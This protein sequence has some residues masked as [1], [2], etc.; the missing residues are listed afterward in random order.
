MGGQWCPH[1]LCCSVAAQSGEPRGPSEVGRLASK[2][3][4]QA[5]PHLGCFVDIISK[6]IEFIH[7]IP[8]TGVA[9]DLSPSYWDTC[10]LAFTKVLQRPLDFSVLG[11][12]IEHLCTQILR[13]FQRTLGLKP[14]HGHGIV[15]FP[16]PAGPP[17]AGLSL[18][19]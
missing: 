3:L 1:S 12:I 17:C 13:R 6:Q 10:L 5:R 8:L 2:Y 15:F 7:E 19:E 9:G 11:L 4:L 18:P 16:E 14:G